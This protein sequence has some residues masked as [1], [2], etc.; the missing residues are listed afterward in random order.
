MPSDTNISEIRFGKTRRSGPEHYFRV[1]VRTDGEQGFGDALV[2]KRDDGDGPDKSDRP[3]RVAWAATPELEHEA[4]AALGELKERFSAKHT[5]NR[6][7]KLLKGA[8]RPLVPPDAEVPVG[9]AMSIAR[10]RF[11]FESRDGPPEEWEQEADAAALRRAGMADQV[12]DR[13]NVRM[14]ELFQWVPWF[15]ELAKKVREG[16][17]KGLVERAKE[18]DWAGLKCAVLAHGEENAD[19]LTFFYHLASIAGGTTEKREKVYSSVADVFG[20]ESDLDYSVNNRFI[21]PIPPGLA[22]HFGGTGADPQLLWEMFDQACA[23]DATS[24]DG[25]RADTFARTLEISGV[26]VPK[27]TQALFLIN[28][29]VFQPFDSNALMSLFKK[30][31]ATISW[32]EY[33]G[34]MGRIRAVFPGCQPYELNIIGFLWSSEY[35]P[36]EGNGWYQISASDDEWRDFRDNNWVHHR[37]LTDQQHGRPDEPAPGDVVLVRSGGQEGRGIGIVH[38]YGLHPHRGGGIH[39]LWVNKVQAPL[40][41]DMPATRFSKVGRAAYDAFAKSDAYSATLRLLEPPNGPTAPLTESLRKKGLLF[42]PEL[43]ANYLLALQTKRFAILTGISGTGKTRIAKAVAQHFGTVQ[44]RS[45]PTPQD[46]AVFREVKPADIKFAKFVV[47]KAISEHLDIATLPNP[48][49]GPTVGV[50]YP[51]GAARLRTYLADGKYAVLHLKGDIREWF[52]STLKVGNQFWLRV[53]PSE[54]DDLGE[55]EIGLPTEFVEQPLDNYIVVPVRPDWVDNR[56]LLGYFNPL[57][58]KYTT[59][60]FL[61]LLLRARDE[62]KRAKKASENPHPFFVI[63]DEMNLARVEHYFSDFLSALESDEPIPLH[64]DERIDSG[65][66][67]GPQVPKTLKIPGNVLFTGTVNVD[68]TTYMFSP[69]VLDRAFTIEFDQV[70]LEGFTTGRSSR[71]AS[72]LTLDGAKESLDLLRSGSSGG[73]DWKPSRDDWVKFSEETPG[74][75]KALLQL[76]R[77]LEEQ[78]RHF[79]YRVANEIARF[80]NLAREQAADA[81]AAANAAFDLALLQKV[82]PKFHGTQRELESLLERIFH[83]AAHGADYAPKPEQTVKPDDWRVVAGRL[84][85]SSGNGASATDAGTETGEAGQDDAADSGQT[86]TPDA[87]AQSP[88]YPRTGAKVLRMLRRLRDRGF[89]SFIE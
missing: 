70:D 45:V 61:D 85:A 3:Y 66:S 47:P 29:K 1:Q 77:I 58:D 35:L 38:D 41:G 2:M 27:L 88:V 18:V 7:R 26:G 15:V 87:G 69:K 59:T 17:R 60:P 75:R 46:D 81:A 48:G 52:Q 73:D 21:F 31:P 6:L 11:P 43:V 4:E 67:Q 68:E 49:P 37:G 24:Y 51:N 42:S 14:P 65:D 12:D 9:L 84:V 32:G 40:A 82:L 30:T 20:I 83:F 8:R 74:L 56:G 19:P 16:R 86:A 28:P 71:D 57:T 22:V 78:H 62:Q 63:L 76:H 79:G 25:V 34:E 54:T 50:R 53:H 55:I 33:V 89:T 39:V 44:T 72:A 5:K 23:A 64:D 36:R 13:K 10:S 80:V